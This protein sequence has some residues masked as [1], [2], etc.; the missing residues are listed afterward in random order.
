M[1]VTITIAV[2]FVFGVIVV[3]LMSG[4]YDDGDDNTSAT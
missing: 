2:I 1:P 4:G 3:G